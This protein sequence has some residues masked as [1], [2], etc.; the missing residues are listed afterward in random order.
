MAELAVRLSHRGGLICLFQERRRPLDELNSSIVVESPLGQ[1]DVPILSP[2][3]LIDP[4]D[5]TLTVDTGEGCIQSEFS[6][7]PLIL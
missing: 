2:L 6:D 3:A 4:N 5:H 1:H 7:D